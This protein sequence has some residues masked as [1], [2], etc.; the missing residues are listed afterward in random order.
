M[1]AQA[2][3][4]MTEEEYETTRKA[5]LANITLPSPTEHHRRGTPE[6][7]Q[8]WVTLEKRVLLD[9]SPRLVVEEHTVQLPDGTIFE[10]WTWVATPEYINILPVTAKG[11]F[12]VLKQVKY[13]VTQA[14]GTPTLATC[15]GLLDPGETPSIAAERELREEMGLGIEELVS[16]GSY[17]VDG[18]RGAGVAHLFLGVGAHEVKKAESD[19]L[20]AK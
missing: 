1:H 17:A 10:D 4:W 15:G 16:L 9:R 19:D 18:N 3:D 2:R 6:P 20:E 5:I 7:F 13:A 12:L 8:Q 11:E 14:F